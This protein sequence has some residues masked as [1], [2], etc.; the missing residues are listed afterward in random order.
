[1]IVDTMS[2]AEVANNML[3][4]YKGCTERI[5]SLLVNNNNKYRRIILKNCGRCNFKSLMI[6]VDN[7][8][9]Y[10]YP[11]SLS[12]SDYKKNG[13][14]YSVVGKVYYKNNN[15]WCFMPNFF[16]DCIILTHHFFER[17]NERHL[18]NEFEMVND[19]LVR[20]YFVETDFKC[21][22]DYNYRGSDNNE[23]TVNTNIGQ[24]CGKVIS[25]NCLLMKT[26]ID[27]NTIRNGCKN[28]S[29]VKT[30]DNLLMLMNKTKTIEED[31]FNFYKSYMAS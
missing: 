20:R 26:F 21:V 19:E 11:Y 17:Y 25:N 22:I 14:L 10:I 9:F 2:Y 31:S 7:I 24:C 3:S 30:K 13:L 8:M 16:D 15:I 28:N 12:K 18:D 5:A 6:K 4:A 1:M 27:L 23:V 29:I